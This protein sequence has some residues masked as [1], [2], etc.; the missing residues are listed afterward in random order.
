ME[1]VVWWFL[2]VVMACIGS[3]WFLRK[4]DEEEAQNKRENDDFFIYRKYHK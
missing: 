4:I 1:N 3:M 2:T